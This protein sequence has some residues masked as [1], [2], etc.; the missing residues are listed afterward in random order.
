MRSRIV[1]TEFNPSE[2]EGIQEGSQITISHE[3][4]N[5]FDSKAL[6]VLFNDEKIGYI[7]KTDDIYDIERINFPITGK[8]V[9][10]YIK[11]E[12]DTKF[13]KHLVNH[14]VSC[15]IEIADRVEL[16]KE[17]NVKSFNEEGVIINFNED[18]HTYTYQGRVLKGAT[19]TIKK[20][21]EKFDENNIL[22]QCEKYWEIDRKIIKSAWELNRDVSAGFGT[23]IH[24]MIEFNILYKGYKKPKDNTRCFKVKHPI[25][26]R[27]LNEFEVLYNEL[28]IKGDII[29]EALV[30]DVE[31]DICGLADMLIVT[32]WNNK[33]C[34][35]V[36]FKVNV[37]FN[38]RKSVKFKNIPTSLGFTGS[39]LD[40]LS[41]Q[42]RVHQQMLQK[43]GWTVNGLH[44]M[45]FEDKWK[46]FKVK[47]ISN[48]NIL[49]GEIN[50]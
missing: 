45:V 47:D 43:N 1:G 32:D 20:F 7:S 50:K 28:N 37:E 13:K 4:Y 33:I 42:L 41:L 18:N 25:L 14:L 27:I 44:A 49:T 39:K 48:F 24:K 6:V 22:P 31:N 17:D 2:A 40:K 10:F 46:H 8:V 35:L 30:S 9:D 5:Q 11:D 19:T 34:E 15:T 12:S 29:P 16:K 38:K 21:I 3:P 26:N 23:S 36:D